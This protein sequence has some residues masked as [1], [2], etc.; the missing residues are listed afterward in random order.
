MLKAI[1][2]VGGPLKGT[3]FRPLSLDIAKPL[4]SVAGFP[5]I[6][7]HI[8]ACLS[9]SNLKE[10]IIL[11]YYPANEF[12]TFIQ[13]MVQEYKINIRYLQEFTPL[14]TAGGLYHFRDQ[15]KIGNPKAFFVLNGDVCMNFP[16]QELLDA[17][18]LHEDAL[19]TI[20]VTE[21]TR[22]Q[23]LN[24]GCVV[25]NKNTSEVAHYVEKPE[26]F[27]SPLINCG[28]YI[29][30]VDIFQTMKEIFD[31]KQTSFCS[32]L[33][34]GNGNESS[35]INLE[36][37]ILLPMAGIGKL[38]AYKTVKWWSQLKTA[39]SAIYANRHYL[40]LY[41]QSTPERL[42]EN[43]NGQC[44]IIGDVF[45]HPTAT[46]DQSAVL[47]PNVSIGKN[48]VVGPGV[49]IRESIILS[50]ACLQEHCLILYSIIGC[51]SQ[52]GKWARVEGTPCD[53]NPNKP[54]AKMD[55]PPL[56]NNDGRL[57]PS[58]TVLGCNVTIS[59]EIIVLNS[60]VLPHKELTRNF[61]NEIIL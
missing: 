30:S 48:A 15:I 42:A 6:Q 9:L 37:E 41:Q 24:Y 22:Q 49:R 61:K 59:S 26:T 18:Q 55:N 46:V 57:N 16:L 1:I 43:V 58:I 47:G 23:S 8:E 27:V 12:S 29:F 7:H 25:L 56:F 52:I 60:I 51:F 11:G 38:F 35:L 3:R 32:N 2:L 13:E 40:S 39:G 33:S 36:K 21:A 31:K 45:I 54:F 5:I 44:T 53:P 4:F 10:I 20:V 28:V 14:G 50:G 17:H 19:G 34:N